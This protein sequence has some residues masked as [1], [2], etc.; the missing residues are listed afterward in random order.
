MSA[1]FKVIWRAR[2]ESR[3]GGVAGIAFAWIAVGVT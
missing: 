2:F 1:Y 3:E